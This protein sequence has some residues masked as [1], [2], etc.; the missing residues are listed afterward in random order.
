MD[1]RTKFYIADFFCAQ[2]KIVVELDGGI[3]ALQVEYD[4]ERDLIM[5]ELG[6]M[7]LRFTNDEVLKNVYEV[8]AKIKQQLNMPNEVI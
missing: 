7:V 8:L 5:K 3:H 2:K 6:L 1:R 4:K